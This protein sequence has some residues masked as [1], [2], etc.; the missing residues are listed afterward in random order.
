MTA[1]VLISIISSGLLYP[2]PFRHGERLFLLCPIY[3]ILR[4]EDRRSYG[5][6]PAPPALIMVLLAGQAL[7]AEFLVAPGV[8]LVE[9]AGLNIGLMEGLYTSLIGLRW[10]V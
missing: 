10:L 1:C 9:V 8:D 7:V 5:L 2:G 6:F 3:H 4:E